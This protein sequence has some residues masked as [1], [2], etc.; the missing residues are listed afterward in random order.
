MLVGEYGVIAG[1]SAL[2]IP[3]P[4][5]NARIRLKDDIPPGKL[6]EAERSGQY[7]EKIF[8][9]ISALP[10]NTF[11]AQPDLGQFSAN[12]QK[13][14]LDMNIPT[15]Y[16]IGSS[17][18]VSAAIYDI[19]FSGVTHMTLEQKRNDLAA[20]ESYF[21]GKSSGVDPLTCHARTPLYFQCNGKISMVELKPSQIP[22]GYRFFLLDSGERFETGPL[23]KYFLDQMKISGFAA[24]IRN[25]YLILNQRLIETLLSERQADAGMLLRAISDFQFTHFRKMI[26]ASMIDYWIE[27]QISNEFY[28]KLNGSGG[29][30]MLGITH[31]SST[32]SLEEKWK[33]KLIWI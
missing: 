17:G 23:V 3:F 18:A 19:F 4:K 32:E 14:W 15:G 22:G 5:F 21:H 30:F 29:G 24:A 8:L 27:G 16:G 25:E 11:H 20:I 33:G 2:T 31:E 28:L 9:F 13:Y 1:G 6:D 12:L 10:E 7:L 26:P